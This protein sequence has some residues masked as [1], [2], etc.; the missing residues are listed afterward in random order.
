MKKAFKIA[1]LV[2]VTAA[3]LATAAVAQ[4]SNVQ[5][6]PMSTQQHQQMM[7]QGN[8][9]NMPDMMNM[10][11]DPKMRQQMTAMMDGCHKMMTQMGSMHGNQ[12]K[13]TR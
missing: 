1:A 11:N 2:A 5:Q 8:M 13:T 4:Q 10:M 3:G 7:G 6:P 9:S 12:Q